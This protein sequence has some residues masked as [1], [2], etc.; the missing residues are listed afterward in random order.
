MIVSVFSICFS[1]FFYILLH[2]K[3]ETTD[4]AR[5]S[6]SRVA[7]ILQNIKFIHVPDQQLPPPVQHQETQQGEII[8]TI[9]QKY[10]KDIP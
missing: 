10:W 5:I 8:D 6:N 2:L 4:A 9:T 7:W 3:K 1:Y